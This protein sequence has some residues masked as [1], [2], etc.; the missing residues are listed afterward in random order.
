MFVFGNCGSSTELVDVLSLIT[1]SSL[2]VIKVVLPWYQQIKLNHIVSSAIKDWNIVDPKSRYI[3]LKYA[4]VGRIVLIVQMFGAYMTI[5][6]LIITRLPGYY[7]QESYNN[8]GNETLLLRNIPIGPRCWI[9][10]EMPRYLYFAYYCFMCFHLIILATAYLGCDVFL[11]GTCMHVVSQFEI[12]YKSVEEIDGNENNHQQRQL[13]IKFTKRHNHLLE[14][15][16]E[17][18]RAYNII[19]FFVVGANIFLISI[20][21]NYKYIQ[22]LL[23][24]S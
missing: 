14:L 3:M 7:V 1:T 18:E 5:F 20:S 11:F 15:A 4:R 19:I 23:V 17:F 16:S 8:F 6:P 12:L 2:A 10:L 13:I 21:G 24:I 22:I 9:S